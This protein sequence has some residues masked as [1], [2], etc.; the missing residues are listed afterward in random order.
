MSYVPFLRTFSYFA[1]SSLF[2][3]VGAARAQDTLPSLDSD[4][5]VSFSGIVFNR[6]T[7]TFDTAATITNTSNQILSGQFSFVLPTITPAS[8]TLENATCH[9]PDDKPVIVGSFP[10]TG[11]APAASLPN[12]VLKFSNPYRAAFTYTH[13]ILAGN[14]CTSGLVLI[15]HAFSDSRTL[16]DD[17]TILQS[18]QAS[19]PLYCQNLSQPNSLTFTQAMTSIQQNL[20]L[21][22]GAGA[23][24]S[25]LASSTQTNQEILVATAVSAM[26][27]KN[28]AGALAA[29]LAAHQN[30]PT[31]PTHLVNAAGAAALLGMPNEA[32]ALLD[33]AD[34]MGGDFGSP[35]GINGHA[36]ALNNRGFAL[37]QLGQW[38]QAQTVLGNSLALEPFMAEARLNLGIAHLCQGDASTGEK[39]FRAGLI[40]PPVQPTLDEAFDLSQGVPP[41]L[42]PLPYPAVADQLPAFRDYYANLLPAV[43]GQAIG[44]FNQGSQALD[45]A[46]QQLFANP[47]P[48]IT[49]VRRADIQSAFD[50][51]RFQEFDPRS[52]AGLSDL[53]AVEQANQQAIN[54]LA[55]ELSNQERA[56]LASL[57][58]PCPSVTEACQAAL[59]T[60]R[61][62]V[63]Q[64]LTQ[65]LYTQGRFDQSLRAFADP[66]YHDMTGLLANI[67]F[68]LMHQGLS[69]QAQADDAGLYADLVAGAF[70]VT[71]VLGPWWL[72]SQGPPEP[73]S[74]PNAMPNPGSSLPCP[75]I[76][77]AA[78]VSLDFFGVL[79]I[80]FNCEKVDATLAEPGIGL[81]AQLSVQRKGDWTVFVGAKGSLPGTSLGAKA[82]FFVKGNDDSFTDA[83]IKV[84]QSGSIGP[85]KFE[86]PFGFEAGIAATIQCLTGGCD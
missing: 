7:N 40:R 64:G 27:G 52:P 82:G 74:P 9:T 17:A 72:A 67:E 80:S 4:L 68:P 18:L 15:L 46:A 59:A 53:W 10:A 28:G 26:A 61:S 29:L 12:V 69:L 58:P 49:D 81:F 70:N 30:D 1:F 24:E 19:S 35:M 22:A 39:A 13:T 66:W 71:N 77:K 85:L 37:L 55:D 54:N 45:Q 33:A 5:N 65:F 56:W 36:L 43:N 3:T 38:S 50:M 34:A 62:L 79:A 8:V 21:I 76:L 6:A 23:L 60:G 31:N 51:L 25:V 20:D 48:I 2:M 47:P 86:S 16:P 44:L 42:P 78:K 73:A 14:E 57:P 84:S 83:G 32:L 11:L 63:R 75:D 41:N